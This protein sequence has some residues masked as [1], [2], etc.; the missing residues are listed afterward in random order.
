MAG[1]HSQWGR[2]QQRLAARASLSRVGTRNVQKRDPRWPGRQDDLAIAK[3]EIVAEAVRVL[4][5]AEAG[6]IQAEVRK[7]IA[8][9]KLTASTSLPELNRLAD[10]T[11]TRVT[12]ESV[13]DVTMKLIGAIRAGSRGVR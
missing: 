5:P 13:E 6:R 1:H 7:A 11:T 12:I 3:S 9:G 8:T 2:L 10:A 4:G